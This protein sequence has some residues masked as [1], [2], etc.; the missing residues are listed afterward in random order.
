[1]L[2]CQSDSKLNGNVLTNF[3]E[4]FE[5]CR[6]HLDND[7]DQQPNNFLI[8]FR[9]VFSRNLSGLGRTTV[10]QPI[11]VLSFEKIDEAAEIK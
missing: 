11:R 3:E 5:R 4:L 2:L 7:Q 6:Q 10:R 9:D 1:M 8:K